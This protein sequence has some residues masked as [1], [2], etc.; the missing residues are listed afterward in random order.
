MLPGFVYRGPETP[1]FITA[2]ENGLSIAATVVVLGN[3]L[4]DASAPGRLLN[5]RNIERNGF[6]L[7]MDDATSGHILSIFAGGVTLDGDATSF[8]SSNNLTS[9]IVQIFSNGFIGKAGIATGAGAIEWFPGIGQGVILHPGTN[10]PNPGVNNMLID[11]PFVRITGTL[12]YNRFV[13]P[14]AATPVAVN[15]TTDVH[16]VFTNEGAA[17]LTV[18]NLPAAATGLTYTF[19]NQNANN[20]SVDAAAGDTIRVGAL[21][22]AAGGAI[23][24]TAIGD[25]VTLVAINA[26][27]WIA[28]ASIGT[29]V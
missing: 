20:I 17:A 27:E 11:Y 10:P 24:S 5:N 2:A 25:T 26:T 16:K 13:S 9:Q 7:N 3:D 15:A 8:V 28:V 6:A 21:V 14:Q 23:T 12:R 1:G 19:Y 29:F 18:F 4:G 22:T